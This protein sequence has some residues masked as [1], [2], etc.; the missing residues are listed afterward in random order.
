MTQQL[1]PLFAAEFLAFAV[2]FCL[3][4]FDPHVC[5]GR[6]AGIH[7]AGVVDIVVAELDESLSDRCE[8]G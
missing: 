1:I 4:C 3:E 8:R 2:I 5:V 6:V 7:V